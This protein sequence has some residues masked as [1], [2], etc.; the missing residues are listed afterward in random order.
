M[1][2]LELTPA[3]SRL[4]AALLER[5]AAP[6]PILERLSVSEKRELVRILGRLLEKSEAG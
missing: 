2:V 3:G 6:P 1:K 5:I 4:R